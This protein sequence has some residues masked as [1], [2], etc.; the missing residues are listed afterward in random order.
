M[1]LNVWD[2]QSAY[3]TAPAVKK[4]LVKVPEIVPKASLV[5]SVAVDP[6]GKPWF[7]DPLN[8]IWTSTK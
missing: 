5:I 1:S 3:L 6:N 4:W 8:R 7:V 2:E